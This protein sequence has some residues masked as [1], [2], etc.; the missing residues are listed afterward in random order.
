MT[1]RIP[2]K[3]III[4]PNRQRQEFEPG[5]LQELVTSIEER[6]LLQAPVLRGMPDGS[7]ALVAGERRL[8][9]ITQIFA[10]GGAFTY[11][12]EL[13]EDEWVP[14]TSLGAL[15]PLEAEEAELDEN[16][17]RKD[18]TWQELAAAHDRLV[19]LRRAQSPATVVSLASVARE[20]NPVATKGKAD[21]ELGA[22][23][24]TLRTETIVAKHLHK[25][26]IAG[27]KSLNEAM[28]I[29]KRDE[30]REQNIA[31]AA[32]VG[33]TLQAELH[34]LIQ[35]DCLDW[36]TSYTGD[37]FDVILTDPPYGMGADEFG[38]A[39][40]K[41]TSIVHNYKDDLDSWRVLMAEW[42]GLAYKVAA[43]Q[44]HAYVFCDFDN[45]HSLKTFMENAGWYVFRTPLI[46]HKV[47]S[48]R[49]PRP[50]HGPRRQWEMVLYAI[51]G[52]KT[53]THIYPD[54]FSATGD[55]NLGHGAQKP[56]GAYMNLLQ[57]SVKPGDRVLDT[58]A[59]TGTILEAAHAL[60][61]YATAIERDAGSYGICIKR[62][63]QLRELA[64]PSP[65]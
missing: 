52:D 39:A 14:Y 18:L 65:I 45:F 27:A 11:N 47:N 30:Q 44:A 10:L 34:S 21:G 29:L 55:T 56:V 25:P 36:M 42:C 4:L 38:D 53:V 6:G 48:G 35:A 43:E 31:L 46:L 33:A 15:T 12:G 64:E 2:L 3:S 60:K 50:M 32:K 13:F 61:C 1:T 23:Q 26:E 49:V 59:G 51:K 19:S 5:A 28:K 40:G 37:R 20:L 9:A 41:M 17:K 54:V 8:K 24:A 58:F 22:Y 63:E 16:L 57:R 62:L 7:W